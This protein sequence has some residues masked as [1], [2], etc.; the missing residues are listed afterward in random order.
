MKTQDKL[1]ITLGT[2]AVM[3]VS[4]FVGFSLFATPDSR[5]SAGSSA[6]VTSADSTSSIAANTNNTSTQN[7]SASNSASGA[8]TASSQYKDGTYT[9]T[10]SYSVP[11]GARNGITSTIVVSGGKITSVTTSNDYSDRES[12]NY[13][14]WF[15]QE[16]SSTVT[17]QSLG[18]VSPS[19]VGGAS[20]TTNAFNDTLDTIRSQAT[21]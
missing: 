15:N 7:S 3:A 18:D 1:L 20:L 10:S 17:G 13:I 16:I 8:T 5:V 19:R 14:D 9:A 21:A 12:G 6:Q 4:G 11:H 2:A